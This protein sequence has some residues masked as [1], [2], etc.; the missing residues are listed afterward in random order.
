VSPPAPES[1]L[2]FDT[3]E[4]AVAELE[5]RLQAAERRGYNARHDYFWIGTVGGAN[6]HYAFGFPAREQIEQIRERLGLGED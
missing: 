4:D 6:E 1:I 2:L 5:A 3:A